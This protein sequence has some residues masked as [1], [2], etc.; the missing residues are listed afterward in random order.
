MRS[1]LAD[2]SDHLYRSLC[3]GRSACIFTFVPAMTSAQGG[4]AAFDDQVDSVLSSLKAALPEHGRTALVIYLNAVDNLEPMRK[5][6]ATARVR[7][8]EVTT[9]VSRFAAEGC[10][11]AVNA[12]VSSG[13]QA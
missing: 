5:K 10:L 9:V 4:A 3:S 12:Y 1:I 2:R 7:A 6:L 8:S 13:S 11:V